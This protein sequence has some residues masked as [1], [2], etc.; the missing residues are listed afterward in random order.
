MP[1]SDDLNGWLGLHQTSV[2]SPSAVSPSAS[3]AAGKSSALPIDAALGWKPCCLACVQKV[4]KS[5]GI[6]TPVM[7]SQLAFLNAEIWALKSVVRFG[8]R[9]G[10]VSLKPFCASTGG[11]PSFGSP[12]ALPSP[13]LGNRPPTILLV[14]S[15]PHMLVNTA[16]MSSSPQKK[17]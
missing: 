17:W 14:G 6:T 15:A 7:I 10:S 3:T 4:L 1:L 12:Q 2:L 13:S 11:K 8:K 9:P 16:M 5:G